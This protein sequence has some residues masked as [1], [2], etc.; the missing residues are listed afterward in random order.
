M[1][2][3]EL[4]KIICSLDDEELKGI[5]T[6]DINFNP[7]EI[8]TFLATNGDFQ[9]FSSL[10]YNLFKKL[11]IVKYAV[12]YE[13]YSS[14]SEIIGV[15]VDFPF[16]SMG[17]INSRHF[18]GI[19]EILIYDFYKRNRSKYSKVCDIGCNVGLHSK[20]LCELGYQVDSYEPDKTHAEI[21]KK[22][23]KGYKN[24]TFYQKAVSSYSGK[25]TFTR[26]L[27]NTTGSYINDKKESFGPTEK[28]EVEVIDAKDL[29]NKYDLIKMD[30]EGSEADVL[31]A[32]EISTFDKTDII[33]EV[34]TS[35]TRVI[36]WD[37]FNRLQ[38]PVYAQKIGWRRIS[39][40]DDL[41]T[42]HREGSIFISKR[43]IF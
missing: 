42:S 31:S 14:V 2:Q 27:N 41:P 16:I 4:D 34:S 35:E 20:I 10:V 21:S 19:D 6:N 30:I 23:L 7:N 22:Y 12:H 17:A 18:F 37:L 36:L 13:R 40:L 25:A 24:N 9:S 1:T 5:S 3:D 32:L 43:N 38:L 15:K 29:S 33:A 11:L 26:I 8:I 28:Y 39:G